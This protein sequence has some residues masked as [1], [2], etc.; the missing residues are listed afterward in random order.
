MNNR[1]IQIKRKNVI[2]T[3][4]FLINQYMKRAACD[5]YCYDSIFYTLLAYRKKT[6]LV[7][8][9]IYKRNEEVE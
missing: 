4:I 8:D 6:N 7:I 9:L 5:G 2:K 1:K 3:S